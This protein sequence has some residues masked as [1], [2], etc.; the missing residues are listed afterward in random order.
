MRL[1]ALIGAFGSGK[2]TCA[3]T[4]ATSLAEHGFTHTEVAIVVNEVGGM[5]E[6][7]TPHARVVT[8][9]NGCFTCQDEAVLKSELLRLENKGVKVVIL[10]G[11]G[12][13]SGEETRAF[14]QSSGYRFQIIGVLDERQHT[15]NLTSYGSLLGTHVSAATA[16]IVVTKCR[17]QGEVSLDIL[18][19]VSDR[20]RVAI[21]P[22]SDIPENLPEEI[23]QRC[24]SDEDA[25]YLPTQRTHRRFHTHRS[26]THHHVHE[27]SM[28]AMTLKSS[29]QVT[30]LQRVLNKYIA[31]GQVRAKGVA[32]RQTFNVAPGE[33]TWNA[34]F[35]DE[36]RAPFLI[37]YV[38][39]NVSV[40][41]EELAGLI[42]E[43]RQGDIRRSYEILRDDV[44]DVNALIDLIRE[45]IEKINKLIPEVTE[46]GHL[47]TH[48]EVPLQLTK[49]M[50]RRPQVKDAWFFPFIEA[51][52]RYWVSCADHL[53]RYAHELDG[54]GR[55]TSERELGVSLAWW[56]VE[57]STRLDSGLKVDIQRTNPA[58]LVARGLAAIDT[59][60]EDSLMRYWQVKE[61]LC[62]LDFGRE[63]SE[64]EGLVH[65]ARSRLLSL[66]PEA[67][68]TQF[69]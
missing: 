63:G 29:V 52:L 51:C 50:V 31:G 20:T 45:G 11:F 40:N 27:W 57:F 35:A 37:L 6:I 30:D 43:I 48:P 23:T 8:M 18:T 47:V 58:V 67:E 44:G 14:L 41:V 68:R 19:F 60:R 39:P 13:V 22:L 10:E 24:L 4:L 28:Y 3:Q 36:G 9:P 5:T 64:A 38:A 61:Y 59:L 53:E 7:R 12:I 66:V 21:Y 65:E 32:G 69:E 16:G 54:K 34:I 17:E 49:E 2:S 62:A 25:Q 26:H 15:R 55:A 42:E 46:A 56:A 1:V 33:D